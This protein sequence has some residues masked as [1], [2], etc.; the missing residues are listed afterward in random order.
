[1]DPMPADSQMPDGLN[2]S[3]RRSMRGL[4]D[5]LHTQ[6]DEYRKGEQRPLGGYVALMAAYAA[7]TAVASGA[8]KALGRPAP[9]GV[10]P[11]EAAQLA[12]ATHK[13]SRLIAKDPVTSP[14]RSPFTTYAGTSAPGELHEE[15]RGHGLQHSVGE[16]LTCP[17][18]MAQWV[19]TAFSLGLV[20]APTAT[21]M[22]LATFS[23]VAGADFLH[24][25]YVLLQ[26]A[27][28]S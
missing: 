27:T 5:W 21:R 14:L 3:K 16:L 19:A 15:V 18:C 4:R 7:G 28:E 22:T 25:A 12:L 13:V 17:M 20:L 8:A 2:L 26:Q 11:W 9:R 24:H 23:A 10:T 1:M 6:A